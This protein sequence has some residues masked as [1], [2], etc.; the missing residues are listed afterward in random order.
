MRILMVHNFY[1]SRGGEEACLENLTRTLTKRGHEVQ[2][3]SEDNQR[4]QSW[5]ERI[6]AGLGCIFSFS[7]FRR[8]R[9]LL[10]D[11]SPDVVHVHNVFPLLSPSV[12]WAAGRHARVIQTVHNYRFMCANGLF[13]KP[14]G[15]RCERCL[16]GNFWNAVR[17]VCYR[18]SRLESAAMAVSLYIHRQLRTY[19]RNIS[20]FVAPSAFLKGRLVAAGFPEERIHLIPHFL[21]QMDVPSV[22]QESRRSILYIGRLGAEKGLLTLL[23]AF[24]G[25]Q[26]WTL[27]I[28]GSGP[29]ENLLRQRTQGRHDILL[30]GRLSSNEIQ[31]QM[32]QAICL[33][34]PS[35]CYE[36]FPMVFLEAFRCGL[37]VIA[38]RLGGMEEMVEENVNGLLFETGSASA[39]KA[40]LVRFI[41]D[42]PLQKKL[43]EGA[44][45]T[46]Q[47]RYSEEVVY[48]KLM[49]VYE[50][51]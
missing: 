28:I 48:P 47:K 7:A 2:T 23:A 18:K 12:Y 44:L 1:R 21:G 27:K 26:G 37:P 5:L 10:R 4:I 20:R 45:A 6:R 25:F 29:M 30:L 38:S 11:F 19:P 17:Y 15:E 49:E 33:I 8:M 3:F 40:A 42:P 34:L 16:T 46:F 51:R 14:D 36:N 41:G 35:E 43:R 24:E 31:R 39:L 32:D 22:P 50:S 9:K 13:L